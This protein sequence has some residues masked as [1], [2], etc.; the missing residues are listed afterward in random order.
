[1]SWYKSVSNYTTHGTRK[2]DPN[3]CICKKF[4]LLYWCVAVCGL[5]YIE[6]CLSLLGCVILWFRYRWYGMN[7]YAKAIGFCSFK[8]QYAIILQQ[9][10]WVY[11]IPLLFNF[12]VTAVFSSHLHQ[13]RKETEIILWPSFMLSEFA[14]I[15][16]KLRHFWLIS[17]YIWDA[18]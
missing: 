10:L 18:V 9:T 12:I 15:L 17:I 2:I 3:T 13:P 14:H 16:I 7:C 1:M 4:S 11:F 6:L 5:W 8:F